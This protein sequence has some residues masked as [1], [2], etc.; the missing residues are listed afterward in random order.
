MTS[1]NVFEK[2]TLPTRRQLLILKE[3][4]S[5]TV[6]EVAEV[7]GYSEET[8]R[9]RIRKGELSAMRYGNKYL[10][11]AKD[12]YET[13]STLLKA[14]KEMEIEAKDM[15]QVYNRR[16]YETTITRE[17]GQDV[18]IVFDVFINDEKSLSTPIELVIL[19]VNGL[20]PNP[21]GKVSVKAEI[22][23]KSEGELMGLT[24]GSY[25][26]SNTWFDQSYGTKA[27]SRKW[28][29]VIYW[30]LNHFV[31]KFYQMEVKDFVKE[32]EGTVN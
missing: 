12:I 2:F 27:I 20:R 22:V 1:I 6:K 26:S 17:M 30:I 23:Y 32:L 16:F 4:S 11:P 21:E 18:K 28:K 9:R 15:P 14:L 5:L 8:I 25:W 3:K 24:I 19:Y 31:L 13:V 10:I 7:F 29:T